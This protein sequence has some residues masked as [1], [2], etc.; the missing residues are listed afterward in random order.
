M[1]GVDACAA[2]YAQRN[3]VEPARR[4]RLRPTSCATIWAL[5][6]RRE[7]RRAVWVKQVAKCAV[8]GRG[9]AL[10]CSTA[11]TY[12]AAWRSVTAWRCGKARHGVPHGTAPGLSAH[13]SCTHLELRVQQRAVLSSKDLGHE[14]ASLAQEVRRDRDGSQQELRLRYALSRVGSLGQS[15][16]AP[17]A[18][19]EEH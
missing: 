1:E 2:P 5:Q 15:W 7:K 19:A 8:Q 13:C 14:R 6:R 3:R 9:T 11:W 18:T 12:G 4:R 10:R 16:Q 17:L